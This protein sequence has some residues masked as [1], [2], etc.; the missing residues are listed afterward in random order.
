MMLDFKKEFFGFGIALRV[1]KRPTSIA[2]SLENN[3]Y[4]GIGIT[5]FK[6]DINMIFGISI[7]WVIL[8]FGIPLKK[9]S[10]GAN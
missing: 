4:H 5:A 7:I 10:N 8:A 1:S 2:T 9:T 6:S 3:L